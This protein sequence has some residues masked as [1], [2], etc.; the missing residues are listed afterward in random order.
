MLVALPVATLF[1][2]LRWLDAARRQVGVFVV[3]GSKYSSSARVPKGLPVGTGAG[4]DGQFYYRLALDPTDLARSAF[5]ITFDSLSR[6]ERLGYPFLAW[7]VARGQH[8]S[9]PLAL[10]IVNVAAFGVVALAGGLLAKSAGRHAIWG[11]AFAGY[12]GY[13]WTLAR[14]LTELTAAAFVLLGLAAFAGV[15]RCGA[16]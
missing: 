6:V 14:D 11:L 1:V 4:Y 10:I 7:L 13:L 9:V 2:V 8:G 12:A 5:G 3:A 16:A 15:P